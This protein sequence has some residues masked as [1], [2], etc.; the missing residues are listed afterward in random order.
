MLAIVAGLISHGTFAGSGDEPHYLMIAHSLAFDQDLDLRNNYRD[1]LLIGGADLTPG[2]HARERHGALYSVHDI[3]LP[4]ALAAIVRVAYPLAE[5]APQWFLDAT[6]LTR[7][8]M[9][10]HFISLAI[11]LCAALLAREVFLMLRHLG[12]TRAGAWWW[13]LLFAVT[14]PVLSHSFLCFTEIPSALIALFIFRRL[15]MQ[16]VESIATAG[17]LGLLTGFLVLIH[18][19]NVGLAVGLVLLTLPLLRDRALPLMRF[20]TFVCAVAAVLMVRTV[21]TFLLWGNYVTTPH[22]TPG[23]SMPLMATARECFERLSG[24]LFD[25][26][27]GLI[28]YGPIYLLAGA[29]LIVL[30]R[31]RSRLARDTGIVIACYLVPVLLPMTNMHGWTGGWSPAARFLLPVAP[32]LWVGV[33]YLAM[34]TSRA[35]RLMIAVLVAIQLLMDAYVWQYP[36]TLW[37]DPDGSI[38]FPGSLWLPSWTEPRAA[39]L[40]AVLIAGACAWTLV[41]LRVFTRSPSSTAPIV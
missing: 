20:A 30:F 31:D 38:F 26:D 40:F 34:H 11:A 4:L 27:F 2:A 28:A 23:A 10:R 12:A 5:R 39:M 41:C 14:P 19:R 7:P 17:V 29:G 33:G 32:L 3:G 37:K 24:L 22:A 15:R 18:V 9:L 1:A 8:I 35:G 16:P 36:K 13:S 21:T 6:T 25:R